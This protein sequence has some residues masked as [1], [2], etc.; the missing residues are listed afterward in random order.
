MGERLLCRIDFE[1]SSG[2]SC[3]WMDVVIKNTRV[4]YILDVGGHEKRFYLHRGFIGWSGIG[5]APEAMYFTYIICIYKDNALL[6]LLYH[7]LLGKHI[8]MLSFYSFWIM[9][10]KV[11]V[12]HVL[13]ASFIIVDH[14]ATLMYKPN[15]P[16]VSYVRWYPRQYS[17]ASYISRIHQ[18]FQSFPCVNRVNDVWII[19]TKR[20]PG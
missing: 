8:I 4:Y 6:Q 17:Q 1:I 7:F 12:K 16:R 11:E 5:R 3:G 13:A 10:I 2:S 15:L 9:Y 18:P 20:V 19:S 14:L